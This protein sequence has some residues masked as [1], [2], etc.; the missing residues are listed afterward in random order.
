V[1]ITYKGNNEVN[2]EIKFAEDFDP[3]KNRSEVIIGLAKSNARLKRLEEELAKEKEEYDKLLEMR[4]QIYKYEQVNELKKEYNGNLP[5]KKNLIELFYSEGK[6]YDE[7]ALLTG[8]TPEYIYKV[9]SN[10]R[11][12]HNIS[13]EN[14]AQSETEET[15]R[16][17]YHANMSV[18]EI[19][20][21]AKVSRQYVYKVL[22]KHNMPY[23]ARKRKKGKMS[24]HKK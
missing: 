21:F 24:L 15:I 3:I 19:A 8:S 16:I 9:I 17:G 6:C 18:E 5:S 12:K 4:Y 22:K 14:P 10:Y 20:A 7:I 1:L 2:V 13:I 11:K 23:P